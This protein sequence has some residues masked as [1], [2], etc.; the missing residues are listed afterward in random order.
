MKTLLALILSLTMTVPA[1]AEPFAFQL[2]F[3][4]GGLVGGFTANEYRLVPNDY[5]ADVT[6][7]HITTPSGMIW[8]STD[9][10]ERVFESRN[11]GNGFIFQPII[12]PFGETHLF[13]E[14]NGPTS[15]NQIMSS[16]T[17]IWSETVPSGARISGTGD[18]IRVNSVPL[19]S[20]LWPTTGLGLAGMGWL[21]WREWRRVR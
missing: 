20:M 21:W 5:F 3:T 12:G 2:D 11:F 7:W 8:D 9:Q 6:A 18:W 17:Y 19:P 15:N 4:S 13:V 10:T 14:T 1:W 16:G